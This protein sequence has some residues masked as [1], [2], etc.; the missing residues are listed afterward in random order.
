[1]KE[2]DIELWEILLNCGKFVTDRLLIAK[3]RDIFAMQTEGSSQ[4]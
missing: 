2:L 3:I 4:N 1:M